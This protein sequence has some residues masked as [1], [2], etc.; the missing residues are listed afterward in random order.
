MQRT[1]HFQVRA[2]DALSKEYEVQVLPPPVLTSLNKLPSPQLQFTFPR[3]TG[4]PS[5]QTQTPGVGNINAPVGTFVELRTAAD[6]ELGAAWI[7]YLPEPK[8]LTP[9][10]Y[11][12]PFGAYDLTS[13]LSLSAASHAVWGRTDAQLDKDRRTFTV[14]FLPRFGRLCAAFRGRNRPGQQPPLRP[15]PR[16]DRCPRCNS[17]DR[18]RRATC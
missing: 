12:L 7:E 2:N 16:E 11:L 4:L 1:F 8:S 5:P 14:R 10:T 9:A 18:R 3:Y 13:L 15:P 17:N 6:R